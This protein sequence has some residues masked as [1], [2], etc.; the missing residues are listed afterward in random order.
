MECGAEHSVGHTAIDQ[1]L[2]QPASFIIG[3]SAFPFPTSPASVMTVPCGWEI[4]LESLDQLKQIQ[5]QLLR[6]GQNSVHEG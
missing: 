6:Q 1:E 2:R 3:R 5:K 4:K